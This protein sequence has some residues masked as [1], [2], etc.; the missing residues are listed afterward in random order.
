M[1]TYVRFDRCLGAPASA[2][3]WVLVEV[4]GMSTP[5][6]ERIAMQP[7]PRTYDVFSRYLLHLYVVVFP[8]AIIG[9]LLHDRWMVIPTTLVVV[10]AFRMIERIGS[11][12]TPFANTKQDVPFTA[13]STIV[14]RDL[15][16]LVSG[17][18]RPAVPKPV[19]GYLW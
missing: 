1:W 17:S 6:A 7:T 5:L 18:A 12:D 2:A 16:T 8:F 3:A 10:F 9:S 4:A 13:I 15:L 14:E 19:N 11:I